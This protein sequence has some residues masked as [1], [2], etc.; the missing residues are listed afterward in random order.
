MMIEHSFFFAQ[1]IGFICMGLGIWAWQFKKV[2]HISFILGIVHIGWVAHYGLL[3]STMGAVLCGL[4]AIRFFAA[5]F[6]NKKQVNWVVCL[7][8]IA[9]T[10]TFIMNY[11]TL[12]DLLPFAGTFIFSLSFFK[13]D[14]RKLFARSAIV[15]TSCWAIY[16]IISLSLAGFAYSLF[17]ITSTLIGMARHENWQMKEWIRER[18]ITPRTYP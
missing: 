2:E 14:D 10:V 15:G 1:L 12:T 7:F 6:L 9:I 11:Q 3:T 13:K 17:A 5:A 18:L 8:L 16:A 4:C